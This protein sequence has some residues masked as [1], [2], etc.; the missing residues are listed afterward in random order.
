MKDRN[1]RHF[2]R[3]FS[4][5]RNIQ[6]MEDQIKIHK[7]KF[8]KALEPIKVMLSHKQNILE[9]EKW[10]VLVERTRTSI[11]N[12]PEQYLGADLARKKVLAITLVNTI[13]EE[14]IK[15]KEIRWPFIKQI[16][17]KKNKPAR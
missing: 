8:N 11:I 5:S 17:K 9:K 15:E 1:R 13:F 10:V 3:L 7:S 6:Y 12:Q 4:Q 16:T 14:F 2:R